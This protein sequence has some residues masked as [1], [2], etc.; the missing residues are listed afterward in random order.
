M[1]RFVEDNAYE[2]PCGKGKEYGKSELFKI[3]CKNFPYKNAEEIIKGTAGKQKRRLK[4]IGIIACQSQPDEEQGRYNIEKLP[5]NVRNQYISNRAVSGF[6][7]VFGEVSG[8]KS[9][10]GHMKQINILH[11]IPVKAVLALDVGI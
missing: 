9:K 8:N 7:R 4:H 1:E 11:E 5:E 10:H 3:R 2:Q 6:L